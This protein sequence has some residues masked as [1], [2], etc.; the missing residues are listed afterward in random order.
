[1]TRTFVQILKE[2]WEE[3]KKYFENYKFYSQKIKKE[4]EDILGAV[5]LFVFGSIIKGKF[6]SNSDIDILIIS[7]NLPQ[8]QKERSKIRTKIKSSIN[9]FAPFQIHLATP[10]EYESWYKNFIKEK[11]RIS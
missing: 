5:E 3:K 11:I 9:P 8:S 2:T 6:R 4:A 1:M 7:K 10:E